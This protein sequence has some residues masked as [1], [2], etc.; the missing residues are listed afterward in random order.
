MGS[1]GGAGGGRET[2][3]ALNNRCV[4]DWYLD[5]GSEA[6]APVPLP[7]PGAGGKAPAPLSGAAA[8]GVRLGPSQR[9]HQPA[10]ATQ[11]PQ[12]AG[13]PHDDDRQPAR[14]DGQRLGLGH[15]RRGALRVQHDSVRVHPRR[16]PVRLVVA[17]AGAVLSSGTRSTL[18]GPAI[19]SFAHTT[20]HGPAD[21]AEAE[22]QRTLCP[23]SWA[24]GLERSLASLAFGASDEADDQVDSA[25]AH[26]L[27]SLTTGLAS[28]R[29]AMAPAQPQPYRVSAFLWQLSSAACRSAC[30]G[31]G[32]RRESA[33]HARVRTARQLAALHCE[34]ADAAPNLTAGTI[35]A[36]PAGPMA[37]VIP[38]RPADVPGP[39]PALGWARMNWLRRGSTVSGGGG[40]GNTAMAT[41]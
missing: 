33:I 34:S 23:A 5:R 35:P 39:R 28:H 18:R 4:V 13:Q 32:G 31:A 1:A 30:P 8:A 3:P 25:A 40:S 2:S 24:A 36:S 27:R 16:I 19:A 14:H 6:L 12:L 9:R 21:D 22:A 41:S 26:Q 20:L 29:L 10:P 37:A 11:P 7:A 38:A 17:L 15:A